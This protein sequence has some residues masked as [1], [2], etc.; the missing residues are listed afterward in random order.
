MNKH[1]SRNKIKVDDE[2]YT[3]P[4]TW[5]K[6][7]PY[8]NRVNVLWEPFYGLGHTIKFFKE[9]KYIMIGTKNK[10]FFKNEKDM[11]DCDTVVSN[12]PFSLK[13]RIMTRLVK[14]EK[15]FILILPLACVNSQS[16][17]KCFNNDMS[18]V[19]ILI[20][21]GRIQFIKG[22]KVQ[23]SPSFESCFVCWKMMEEKLVFLN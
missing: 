19:S 14:N 10:D 17:R 23:K 21:K 22:D 13:Y 3:Q 8:I 1:V 7:L 16:F 9:N 5:Q 15:P 6:I 2:Y 12:P 4:S 18:D 20:P 11:R